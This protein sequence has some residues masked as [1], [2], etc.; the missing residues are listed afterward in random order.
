[1]QLKLVEC[2][3][4]LDI[5]ADRTKEFF[6]K[7]PPHRWFASCKA[8]HFQLNRSCVTFCPCKHLQLESRSDNLFLQTQHTERVQ[9]ESN[10]KTPSQ[11]VVICQPSGSYLTL[12]NM[13]LLTYLVCVLGRWFQIDHLV[14]G[15]RFGYFV[16]WLINSFG[17]FNAKSFFV[18]IYKIYKWID[19]VFFFFLHIRFVN[20]GFEMIKY[21]T[22]I[23]RLHH[24]HIIWLTCPI[25]FFIYRYTLQKDSF[26]IQIYLRL[27]CF[28]L[29]HSWLYVICQRMYGKIKSSL[30]H[31][32]WLYVCPPEI[33]KS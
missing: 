26:Y 3:D 22:K 23:S 25:F 5:S 18:V 12:N 32:I 17:L 33:L 4:H 15:V 10:H 13:H 27:R 24:R 29:S 21:K 20:K 30:S 14:P 28:E 8:P 6:F 11:L 1:M 2:S 31:F 7:L 16:K 9:Y 19:I